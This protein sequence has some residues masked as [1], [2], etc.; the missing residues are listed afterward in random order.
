MDDS[1]YLPCQ[2]VSK[3]LYNHLSC[4]RRPTVQ[5]EFEKNYRRA[6]QAISSYRLFWP[7]SLTCTVGGLRLSSGLAAP[8]RFHPKSAAG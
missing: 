6:T 7:E 4:C 1:G 5:C 8:M 3:P 2:L